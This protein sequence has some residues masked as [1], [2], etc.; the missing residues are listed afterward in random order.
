MSLFVWR[1][2]S[3]LSKVCDADIAAACTKSKPALGNVPG[4]VLKCLQNSIAATVHTGTTDTTVSAECKAFVDV[5]EPPDEKQEYDNNLRVRA[6]GQLAMC[7]RLHLV[8][9]ASQLP[10]TVAC[11][12]RGGVAADQRHGE[13][14]PLRQAARRDGDRL[15]GARGVRRSLHRHNPRRVHRVRALPRHQG[16]LHHGPQIWR[17]LALDAPFVHRWFVRSWLCRS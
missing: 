11:A 1:E 15:L 10:D 14:R 8:Q 16:G 9:F 6:R 12:G 4:R 17:C 2:D 13:R 7:L 3:A 5:A